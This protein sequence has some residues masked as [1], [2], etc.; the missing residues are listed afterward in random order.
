MD[1]E[2]KEERKKTV[3]DNITEIVDEFCDNYCRYPNDWDPEQHD[4]VELWDSGICDRCPV[5]RLV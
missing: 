1:E 4:G 5:G 2:K 3:V